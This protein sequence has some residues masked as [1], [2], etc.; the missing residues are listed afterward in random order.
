MDG[1]KTSLHFS[2]P[3]QATEQKHSDDA[4]Q[5][6]AP[7]SRHFFFLEGEEHMV[8]CS[9]CREDVKYTEQGLRCRAC[10]NKQFW[11]APSSVNPTGW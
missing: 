11:A 7:L 9:K 8:T 5:L 4:A 1:W 3:E 10:G 6:L 2:N